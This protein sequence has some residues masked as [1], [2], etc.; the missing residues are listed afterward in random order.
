MKEFAEN[1][2]QGFYEWITKNVNTIALNKKCI[3][4]NDVLVYETEV[5]F[6]Q[7]MCLLS[8]GDLQEVLGNYELSPIPTSIFNKEGNVRF[9]KNK[10]A[11]K[12]TLKADSSKHV[13][14]QPNAVILAGCALLWTLHWPDQGKVQYVANLFV[15]QMLQ[16]LKDSDVYL[17]FN[18]YFDYSIKSSTC[19]ERSKAILKERKLILTT[20]LPSQSDMLSSISNKKQLI[21]MICD[22]LTEKLFLENNPNRFVVTTSDQ[23]PD[24]IQKGKLEKHNELWNSSEEA[25]NIIIHQQMFSYCCC[26]FIIKK[27]LQQTS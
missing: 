13:Q 23:V 7:I 6:S 2:P 21:N 10:A 1:W 27:T 26:T 3:K 25:D 11:L 24:T 19:Q 16:W 9:P 4:V 15:A 5:I 14:S 8:T 12:N 17:I 18:R 20:A 22:D